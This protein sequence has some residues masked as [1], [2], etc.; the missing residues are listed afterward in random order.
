MNLDFVD[1]EVTGTPGI[2]YRYQTGRFPVTSIKGTKCVFV[3]YC[4]E[5]NSIITEPLNERTG[6]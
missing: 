1:I 2:T 5:T 4:Y 6:K 3:L